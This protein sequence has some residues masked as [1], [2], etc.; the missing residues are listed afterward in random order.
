[1]AGLRHSRFSSDATITGRSRTR[2]RAPTHD[3]G[4]GFHT[5][6]WGAHHPGGQVDDALEVDATPSG[7]RL[8]NSSAK[9]EAISSNIYRV[10]ALAV[11]LV[12]KVMIGISRSRQTSKSL[13]VLRPMPL[14]TSITMMAASLRSVSVGVLGKSECPVSTG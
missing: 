12:S 1:M 7:P 6:P 14:A 4:E 8:A 3:I 11:D 2:C 13:S 9:V 5:S 10:L